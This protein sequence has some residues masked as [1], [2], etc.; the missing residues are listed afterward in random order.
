MSLTKP[1]PWSRTYQES[2]KILIVEDVSEVRE[3]CKDLVCALGMEVCTAADSS[4][5]KKL[6]SQDKFSL[7]ISDI[8]MPEMDGLQ[9]T[10]FVREH[11]PETDVILMTGFHMRYS[12]DDVLEA[13]A[14]DF[15]QKPFSKEEF[16][17]KIKR[18][19][20]E[21]RQFQLVRRSEQYLRSL[22]H[23]IPGVV[24]Y[25]LPDGS[26]EFVDN[27]IS[28]LTGYSASSL[29][30]GMEMWK[31][32]RT[33]KQ[34][35]A[36]SV[37]VLERLA[38]GRDS[39]VEEFLIYSRDGQQ[40]WVQLRC[41][42]V[43]NSQGELEQ[44]SCML[45]D[46]SQQKR[47]EERTVFLNRL[48]LS[49]GTDHS[50]NMH[51]IIRQA[52]ILLQA[53]HSFYFQAEGKD[54]E[55]LLTMVQVSPEAE[56]KEQ[57]QAVG[58]LLARMMTASTDRPQLLENL[59]RFPDMLQDDL[60]EHYG[61]TCCLGTSLELGDHGRGVFCVAF[62]DARL[63]S[64]DEIAIFSMLA[65]A[66]EV[67]KER[68][69]LQEALVRSEDKYRSLVDGNLYPISIIDGGQKIR[70]CNRVMADMFKY[71]K[72]SSLLGEDFS[73]LFH[74]DDRYKIGELVQ[75]LAKQT[76]EHW[77]QALE[78][79]GM[80]SDG[81]TLDIRLKAGRILY[82]GQ[83]AIQAILEDVTERKQTEQALRDSEQRYRALVEGANDAVFLETFDG[84]I[85]DA[86]SRACKMLGYSRSEL[87]RMKMADLVR[88]AGEGAFRASQQREPLQHL[89]ET[90]VHKD[91]S[92]VPVEVNTSV[93]QL[94]GEKYLLSVVRDI[95]LRKEKELR[96]K[97]LEQ[98]ILESKKRL[99]AVFD[100]IMSPLS[101]TDLD[102]NIIMVNKATASLFGKKI[103]RLIGR[104][105]YEA[106][107]GEDEPCQNCAVTDTI[108]TG[109][110][111]HRVSTN[112]TIN[113]T[114]EEYTY[115]IYDASGNLSLVIDYGIDVTDKIRMQKQ[116]LQADKMASLGTLAAG[117][118]H[119]IRNP[120]ATINLNTQILLRDLQLDREHQVYMLDIQKEIKK[121]ERIISEI[122]EFSKPKPAHL[123]ET[124]INE[125]VQSVH[126][127]TRVQ[128]RKHGVAVN[129]D[130]AE[131]LPAVLVDP[132]QISQV[133]I[134]LVINA[135]QAMPE[136]GNLMVA[137]RLDPDSG[138][139]EMVVKDTGVGIPGENI[140][141]IFDPFF[142][143]KPEGT[144]LGLAIARQILDKNQAT[145]Q[146]E[147]E[148]GRGTTFSIQFKTLDCGQS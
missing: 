46:I 113:R 148:V 41:Q 74:P 143:N 93:L 117:I 71:S 37:D 43:R 76:G 91:G 77:R 32:L 24:F 78:M 28:E 95:T 62:A 64:A 127:L 90:M 45:F 51:L 12:Y 49:L 98:A 14:V 27:K 103:Q 130:L 1:L 30:N 141:K 109:K 53:S 21:R 142:T 20:R 25:L 83:A 13:G 134:N 50:A 56:V 121:I 112:P 99:M 111:S 104:K 80:R 3:L 145:I 123:V 120:M 26:V 67:E 135:M 34:H 63:V 75:D 18:L 125:V 70:Y 69:E 138:R 146:L 19:L 88:G 23:N 42:A 147:S 82:D 35:N 119:E 84:C 17:A 108:R 59:K 89:E 15:I 65:K 48:F 87:L 131:D 92:W 140:D 9:L 116:L 101:I 86:N 97:H 128:L 114:I 47:I 110:P 106:F 136:G 96:Q 144:G 73:A 107:R 8:S 55:G 7:I 52:G 58:P 118:A 124:N 81:T 132:S 54:K 60:V 139:V 39:L 31:V 40:K 133:V 16:E 44:V 85:A 115:P 61:W 66:L 122:L 36:F 68:K 57:R 105:C 22:L 38:H 10:K 5:A 126:E 137:T 33:E 72:P 2:R 94:K 6:L 100:G 129:L 102:H 29:S 11:Y 4:Q 79:K